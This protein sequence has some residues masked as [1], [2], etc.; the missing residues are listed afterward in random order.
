MSVVSHGLYPDW[1]TTIVYQGMEWRDIA[2]KQV[3][4]DEF[5][6]QQQKKNA[7]DGAESK[8]SDLSKKLVGLLDFPKNISEYIQPTLQF[9][10]LRT[11]EFEPEKKLPARQKMWS[12]LLK[13]LRGPRS[14]PGQYYY[15]VDEVETL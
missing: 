13:C 10:N 9:C 11:V 2:K 5:F 6:P 15:L 14:I 3:N 4:L 7:G 12:W 1:M 8:S